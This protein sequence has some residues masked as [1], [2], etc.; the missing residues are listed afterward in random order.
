ML[1]SFCIYFAHCWR[2]TGI[3]QTCKEKA[4]TSGKVC[5]YV[6]NKN[7]LNHIITVWASNHALYKTPSLTSRKHE[8][9]LKVWTRRSSHVF[10]GASRG[11]LISCPYCN[12]LGRRI[13]LESFPN[14]ISLQNKDF[15]FSLR[16]GLFRGLTVQNHSVFGLNMHLDMKPMVETGEIPCMWRC[17]TVVNG[18][19]WKPNEASLMSAPFSSRTFFSASSNS[20]TETRN[21]LCLWLNIFQYL[22]FTK[23]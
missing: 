15:E 21:K 7:K 17:L 23:R 9:K 13:C 10:R 18:G 20:F 16:F 8:F 6:F 12:Q 11:N 19:Q 3:K 14:A 22:A 5:T 2:E 4:Q 1:L